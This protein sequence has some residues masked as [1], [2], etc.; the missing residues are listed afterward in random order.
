MVAA[1]Y[2]QLVVGVMMAESGV[3][4][5]VMYWKIWLS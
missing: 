2:V 5:V 4:L 3:L 1:E